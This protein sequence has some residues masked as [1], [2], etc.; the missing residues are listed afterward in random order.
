[1]SA[2]GVAAGRPVEPLGVADYTALVE[3]LRFQKVDLAYLGPAAYLQA[4]QRADAVPLAQ[5]IPASGEPSYHGIVVVRADSPA[6]KFEDLRARRFAF[7]E[8]K[9]TSGYLAPTVHIIEDLGSSPEQYFARVQFAGSHQAVLVAVANGHVDGGATNEL[10]LLRMFEKGLYKSSDFKTIWTSE[11]IPGAVIVARSQ[12][13]A[14]ERERVGRAI[15]AYADPVGLERMQN[16]GFVATE[17]SRFDSVRRMEAVKAKL[18][19]AAAPAPAP[20][21]AGGP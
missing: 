14:D 12:M 19:A 8:P 7:V 13:P 17:D 15:L 9:S 5:E 10:D 11:P 2:I 16:K 18:G 1:M 6:T 20:S 3:A 21:P 4:R